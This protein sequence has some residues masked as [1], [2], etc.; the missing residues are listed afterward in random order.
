MSIRWL[1]TRPWTDR[2]PDERDDRCH[3]H[4]CSAV[5]AQVADPQPWRSWS[6]RRPTSTTS[7]S[8][9]SIGRRRSYT[10]APQPK[11]CAA[12]RGDA[13]SRAAPPPMRSRSSTRSWSNRFTRTCAK[14]TVVSRKPWL[15]QRCMQRPPKEQ[16]VH[17]DL[18]GSAD[19]QGRCARRQRHCAGVHGT[20]A[21]QAPAGGRNRDIDRAPGDPE[22]RIRQC[23]EQSAWFE[24]RVRAADATSVLAVAA[25][26]T[27][28]NN[29][30]S[31]LAVAG[32]QQIG[33][34]KAGRA[35]RLHPK[36]RKQTRSSVS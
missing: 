15:A 29:L 33:S 3:L 31:L 22:V 5:E 12:K 8:R 23:G 27:K 4:L 13:R 2:R 14:N 32:I 1:V 7:V 34:A 28:I 26:D 10:S 17:H 18:G 30:E 20:A 16:R 9:L 24:G 25:L 36:P 11:N 35:A 6:R 21:R 19:R